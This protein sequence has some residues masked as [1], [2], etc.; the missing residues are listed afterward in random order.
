VA[1]LSWNIFVYPVKCRP[2]PTKGSRR[3][4]RVVK[5]TY[6]TALVIAVVLI[7]WL[8]S[9]QF[10]NDDESWKSSASVGAASVE[11]IRVRTQKLNSTPHTIQLVASGKTQVKRSVQIKAETTGRVIKLPVEKGEVVEK[12]AL[13][14]L[15]SMEDRDIKLRK[16]EASVEHAELEHEGALK[17]SRQGYQSEVNI[18]S[19]KVDLINAQAE[20]R[21][22]AL[23][24]GYR[25]IRAPFKGILQERPVN[26]GDFLQRGS[27]C[28]EVLDPDPLLIVAHVSEKEV[29]ELVLGQTAKAI[30]SNHVEIEGRISYISH[31]AE[32]VTRTYRIEVEIENADYQLRDGLSAEVILPRAQINAH[33][34][35][36]A[37]LSLSDSGA[38][39]IKILDGTDTVQFIEVEIVSDTEEGVWLTGLPDAIELITLGQE[40]VFDGQRVDPVVEP[41]S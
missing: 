39:G 33:L 2:T 6:V 13:I 35:S 18:A 5:P 7:G 20:Q 10:G 36:A 32:T 25:A 40:L 27:V 11:L 24:L 16:A 34:V 12:G 26:I 19:A 14:C 22:R 17:L 38:I 8:A 15:L 41:A 28:A 30:F 9:G 3:Q 1:E 4:G 37:L 31:S 21:T 29:S 23:D